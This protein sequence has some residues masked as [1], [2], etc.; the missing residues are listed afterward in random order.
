MEPMTPALPSGSTRV[1]DRVVFRELDGESVILHLDSGNYFG[2][3][4]VGTRIW[5]HLEGGSSLD[6]VVAAVVGEFDVD[7]VRARQDVDRL[8]ALLL[9]KG[10]LIAGHDGATP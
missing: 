6:A 9:A 4:D 1:A 10:L 5:R 3:D 7:P 2:L 8:T